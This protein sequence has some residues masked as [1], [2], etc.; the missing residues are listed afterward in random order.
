M[1]FKTLLNLIKIESKR[2]VLLEDYDRKIKVDTI[3]T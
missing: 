2:C 1:K 3:Y